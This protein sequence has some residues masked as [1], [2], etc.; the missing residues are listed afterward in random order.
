MP[1]G[2]TGI[3]GVAEGAGALDREVAGAVALDGAG[4]GADTGAGAGG[5]TGVLLGADVFSMKA[6][7]LTCPLASHQ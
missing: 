7:H 1:V 6:K 5:D 3:A 4:A 2:D